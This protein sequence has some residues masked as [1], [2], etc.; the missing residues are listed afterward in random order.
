MNRS[1]NVRQGLTAVE[2][3]ASTLLASMLMVAMIGVLRG[4]KAQE[5]ALETRLPTPSW[6]AALDHVLQQDLVNSRTYVT[7]PT[8]L[9][10][11]GFA[12]HN[13]QSGAANW[14]PTTITYQIVEEDERNWLVR[15]EG[16]RHELVLANVMSI[17][18]GVISD[19][20]GEV[21]S[22]GATSLQ[23]SPITSGLVVQFWGP[24]DPGKTE[25]TEEPRYGYRFRR[26]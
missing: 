11:K 3:V 10:L 15:H 19:E 7:S 9:V 16:E 20:M 6:Q 23:D 1:H 14:Q 13:S 5:A 25:N 22:Q 21:L 12:G 18:T 17:R 8:A 4:L 24:N 26:P 2:V